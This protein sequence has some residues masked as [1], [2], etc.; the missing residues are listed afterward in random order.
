MNADTKAVARELVA[1]FTSGNSVPVDI[2]HTAKVN[3]HRIMADAERLDRSINGTNRS[4][5]SIDR[6]MT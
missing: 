6:M 4:T 3:G 2:R 1:W 5:K